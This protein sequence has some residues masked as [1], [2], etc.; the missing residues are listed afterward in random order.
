MFL[1]SLKQQKKMGDQ[2]GQPVVTLNDVVTG[3]EDT[4]K[5]RIIELRPAFYY[6]M[7]KKTDHCFYEVKMTMA[8]S[9][10]VQ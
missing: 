3:T 5:G 6:I 7:Y 10:L 8:Q 1:V 2:N 4:S 9:I